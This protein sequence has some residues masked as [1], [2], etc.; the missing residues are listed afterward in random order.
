MNNNLYLGIIHA[1][2][3][4][5]IINKICK[6]HYPPPPNPL[7][8]FDQAPPPSL[9]K[10]FINGWPLTTGLLLLTHAESA[11]LVLVL[12]SFCF[13]L[14]VVEAVATTFCRLVVLATLQCMV[15]LLRCARMDMDSSI[16]LNLTSNLIIH[17]YSYYQFHYLLLVL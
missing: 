9:Q 14:N 17:L 5:G 12:H 4:T 16:Q 2:R 11:A 6:V 3:H 13:S 8:A 1:A 7:S 10:A 15:E